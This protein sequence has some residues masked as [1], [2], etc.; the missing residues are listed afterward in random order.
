MEFK[1]TIEQRIK[2]LK[3]QQETI[4]KRIQHNKP[5]INQIIKYGE[6]LN[7]INIKIAELELML[8]Q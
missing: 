2:D 7:S 1:K 5:S 4:L 3:E 8:W 6:D